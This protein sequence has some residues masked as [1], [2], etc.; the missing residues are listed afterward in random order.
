MR[1]RF[2]GLHDEDALDNYDQA[3]VNALKL[4]ARRG[5]ETYVRLVNRGGRDINGG[6]ESRRAE[7]GRRLKKRG[8]IARHV[9]ATGRGATYAR[10]IGRRDIDGRGKQRCR[11]LRRLLGGEGRL[12][13][14]WRDD[15]GH[16][17]G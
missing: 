1:R 17:G 16:G 4:G 6:H 13:R 9:D 10:Q 12:A 11:P 8:E 2:V 7:H 15:G 5:R 14:A 3:S